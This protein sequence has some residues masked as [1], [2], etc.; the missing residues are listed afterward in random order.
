MSD[1]D[2]NKNIDWFN[3]REIQ[4]ILPSQDPFALVFDSGQ[5]ESSLGNYVVSPSRPVNII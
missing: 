1:L 3:F 4:H 2:N 5:Y